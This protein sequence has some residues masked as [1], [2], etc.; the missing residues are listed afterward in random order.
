MDLQ[1]PAM[2]YS[3]K[4]SCMLFTGSNLSARYYSPIIFL[5]KIHT[6]QLSIVKRK[7]R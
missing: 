6:W 1:L 2:L 3:F 4:T 7:T 5:G